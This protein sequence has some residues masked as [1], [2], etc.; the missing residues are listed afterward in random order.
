MEMR[1]NPDSSAAC[2]LDMESGLFH[3]DHFNAVMG[4][5]LARVDRWGRPLSLVLLETEG[6]DAPGWAEFG[7]SLKSSLR[8]IDIPARLSEK[9]IA[10]LLPDADEARARRWLAGFLYDLSRS[11]ELGGISLQYGRSMALPWEGR[12]AEELLA[13]A[14]KAIGCE[15]LG[16][17]KPGAASYET[18]ATAIA[19]DERSLLFAGFRSLD[20]NK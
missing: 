8:R 17:E 12:Q 9:R 13:M 15:D 3:H 7:L 19:A 11:E 1:H 16:R 20:H 18:S 10:V 4:Q 14:E 2:C 5:E 6:L